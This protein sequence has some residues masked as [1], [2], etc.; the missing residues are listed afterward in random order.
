MSL[1]IRPAQDADIAFIVDLMNHFILHDPGLYSE[2]SIRSEEAKAWMMARNSETNPM[3]VA[4]K[5][6]QIVGLAFARP[7]RNQSGSSHVWES[8]VYLSPQSNVL[9]MGIGS[10]LLQSLLDQLHAQGTTEVI[11]VIDE[12]N[13]ASIAFHQRHGYHFVGIIQRAG[14]KFGRYRN[15]HL[16]Q[17]SQKQ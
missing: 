15:A 5:N 13:A 12:E 16:Y 6:A 4:L 3:L 1:Q 7:F 14:F 8:S 10:H 9:R 2:I 17:L 11:A